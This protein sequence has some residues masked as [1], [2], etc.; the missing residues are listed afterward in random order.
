MDEVTASLTSAAIAAIV[1]LTTAL[2][3]TRASERRLLRDFQLEF[4][5]ERA[6][7]EL[8]NDSEW[9][10]RS[11][12]VIKQHLGGF[13]DDELRRTLVRAGAV[14]FK[15]KSGRELWGLF[16]RTRDLLGVEKIDD[17]PGERW[18]PD[19]DQSDR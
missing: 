11:F 18:E 17:D 7:R 16:E 13:D 4:A 15:S 3:T 14:R 6:A 9:R 8:M 12:K 5:A 19:S 2:I 10:L 1:S